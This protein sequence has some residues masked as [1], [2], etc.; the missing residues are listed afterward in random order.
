M[1]IEKEA[2][3]K[4][5]KKM[6]LKVFEQFFSIEAHQKVTIALDVDPM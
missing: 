2:S 4:E 6:M 1:K 3:M 5:A